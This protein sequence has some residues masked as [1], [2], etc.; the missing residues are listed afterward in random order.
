MN[1]GAPG[2]LRAHHCHGESVDKSGDMQGSHASG[3]KQLHTMV[4]GKVESHGQCGQGAGK[5][6]QK[7]LPNMQQNLHQ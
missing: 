7:R 1:R 3:G 4:S 2:Q 6:H 5:D